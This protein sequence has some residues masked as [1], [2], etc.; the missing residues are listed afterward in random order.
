MHVRAILSR[1][2]LI[3]AVA[4]IFHSLAGLSA[5]RAQQLVADA[6]PDRTVAVGDTVVLDGRGSRDP[7]EMTADFAWRFVSVPPG[8]TAQLS[9]P[10]VVEPRVSVKPSFVADLPGAYVLELVLTESSRISAPDRVVINTANSAPRADAGPDQSVTQGQWVIL[11]GSAS[12]DSDGDALTY[13]WTVIDPLGATFDLTGVNPGFEATLAGTYTAELTVDDSITG[14]LYTDHVTDTVTISTVNV[15]PVAVAGPDITAVLGEK[16]QFDGSLSHDRDGDELSYSWALISV[17][18]LPV[19]SAEE[20]ASQQYVRPTLVVDKEG[21]F[22]VQLTVTDANGAVGRDTLVVS[23]VNAAPLADAGPDQVITPG[24]TVTLDAGGTTDWN[25]DLLRFR[26]ALISRP[27]T[28]VAALDDPA[29]VRPEFTADFPGTYVAQLV[30]DDGA[31][32]GIPYPSETSAAD[33]VVITTGNALPAADAGPP[34]TVAIRETVQLDASGTTDANGAAGLL[35]SWTVLKDPNGNKANFS[36]PTSPT[37]TFTFSKF[38]EHVLQ[39][40]VSDGERSHVDTILLNTINTRPFANAGPEEPAIPGDTVY[41]NG[42]TEP[43]G[44]TPRSKDVDGDPILFEWALIARPEG[45]AAILQNP[46]TA[47]PSIATDLPGYYIAQLIVHE[48][49]VTNPLTITKSSLPATMVV[50]APNSPPVADAGAD[51][52]VYV[53]E[54]VTLDGTGSSDADDDPLSYAWSFSSVPAGSTAALDDATA[55]APV[56]TPNVAGTYVV[57][58]IVNDGKVDSAPDTVSVTVRE[59]PVAEAGPE[60]GVTVGATVQLDGSASTP[61]DGTLTYAWRFTAKPAG[62]LAV[63]SDPAI[64]NPTFTADVNGLYVLDLVVNDGIADSAPDTVGVRAG[65]GVFNTA[66]VLGAVGPQTVELGATLTFTLSATDAD[67]DPFGFFATPLPL[68]AGAGLDAAT[69]AFSFRPDETQVG[70][71][72]IT[73]GVS[74]GLDSDSE[75][76]EITVTAPPAGTVTTLTGRLVDAEAT[77]QGVEGATVS[78]VGSGVSALTAADGSFTLVNLGVVGDQVLEIDAST[79]TGATPFASRREGVTLIADAVNALGDFALARIDLTTQTPY[80][81]VGTTVVTNTTLGATVTIAGG[82]AKDADGNDFAG[83]FTL[84]GLP[85]AGIAALLPPFVSSCQ[86]VTLQSSP[87]GVT[88]T[89]AAS[90]TLG[91]ADNLPAGAIVDVWGVS[92]ATG[93]SFIATSGTVSADRQSI[94]VGPLVGRTPS[95]FFA[96][97]RAPSVAAAADM[98]RDTLMRSLLGGGNVSQAITLPG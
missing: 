59:R 45:S 9:A 91:N 13:R 10:H 60:Q 18:V 76:V 94:V 39:L 78:V 63:L 20:L 17:P 16:V 67:G 51:R 88:F 3:V 68:P 29:S 83:T 98:N 82:T 85:P 2:F 1:A 55:A 26:W 75:S 5:V 81:P 19:P 15:P 30:V 33:T 71:H 35:Y 4:A 96:T 58:L 87:S 69:G 53:G 62:S 61:A 6:G 65:S 95:V 73:F 11:D 79:A 37:P 80:N 32:P 57:Q 12:T 24:E 92:P 86:V 93:R 44:V 31:D 72:T 97:P 49:S 34:Q 54:Q 40:T 84:S 89:S 46:T 56:F 70:V 47:T 22:L 48:Q 77:S 66:P 52:T 8:S 38:G 64:V 7:K 41:L 23:T 74:D 90:V 43:D 50:A 28:S 36:D 27:A 14:H 25:G 21:I 42:A